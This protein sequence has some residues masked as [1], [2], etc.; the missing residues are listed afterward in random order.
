MASSPSQNEYE[1]PPRSLSDDTSDDNSPTQRTAGQ[2]M[3]YGTIS[4]V[5]DPQSTQA[6]Q[7]STSSAHHHRRASSFTSSHDRSRKPPIVRRMSSRPIRG[8]EFSVLDDPAELLQDHARKASSQNLRASSSLRKRSNVPQTPTLVEVD[9]GEDSQTEARAR[10][11]DEPAPFAEDED[12]EGSYDESDAHSIISNA[13]SFTLKDR[14]QAINQT[15]PFG[16]RIWKPA[17]YKK[18]R[19][20]E[21]TTEGDIHSAPGERVSPWL[22]LANILWTV[23]FGWW[24]ALIS[25]VGALVCHAVTFSP[26]AAAYARVFVGL[27]GYLFYPFG[28]YVLLESDE[29]YADEDVGEG[30]SISEWERWQSGDLE[31]GRLFFGPNDG[32]SARRSSLE[33][34][35]A[36]ER[37]RL[38]GPST[39]AA[40]AGTAPGAAGSNS[41]EEQ[42]NRKRRFFGRGKWSIARVVFYA[43]FYC[44]VGPP[45]FL[46]ALICWISVVGIPMGRV[47]LILYRHIRRHPLALSFH[48]DPKDSRATDRPSSILL[49]TYRAA[50]L[51]YWKY[52]I[53]GTNIFFINLMVVVLF[54]IF[55]YFVLY[56]GFGVQSGVAN[57]G[58]IFVLGLL[59]VI[60]LAYFIGQAVASISAQS[61]M[62][63]GAAVNAF[64]STVVEVYLYCVALTEGKSALV[65]G[66]IIGSILA[67]ILF[68]PGISMCFGA[69][70]RKTQRFN[71]KSAGV[72]STMLLFAMIAAFG[73]TIFYQVYGSHELNCFSCTEANA[74][75]RDCR[76]CYFSQEPAATDQ[77]YQ[78]AVLPYSYIAAI[79]LFFSYIIGLCP[80]VIRDS[81][82]FSRI[83]GQSLDSLGLARDDTARG[84]APASAGASAPAAS[85]GDAASQEMAG[86]VSSVTPDLASAGKPVAAVTAKGAA[87]QPALAG[88][89][90][91]SKEE[92]E[93][94]IRQITEVAATA[95]AIAARDAARLRKATALAAPTTRPGDAAK[96]AAQHPQ[97]AAGHV[98]EN[99]VGAITAQQL[100]S[101]TPETPSAGH[102]APNWSKTKSSVILLGTTVL[103]AIIAEILVK[104]VDVVLESVEIEEKFLGITLFALVPNTTEF[105][106][107]ISFAMNG[108]IALSM[109]IGSAYA[110]QVCLLQIPALVFFSG[111]YSTYLQDTELLSHTFNLIFPHWDTVT[112]ILCVFLLSY[113]YGEGKS[114]YFKGS[115]LVLTY[116]FVV[117]GFYFSD[118]NS[119]DQVQIT[120]PAA[121]AGG[122]TGRWKVGVVGAGDALSRA[123]VSGVAA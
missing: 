113:M 45:L 96:G 90:S 119:L 8:Q 114:N 49:C 2:S 53:D 94:L 35:G 10:T 78:R 99:E 117:M 95:A 34:T 6:D 24:L 112:I 21:R 102:D 52:T 17:V 84:A 69:L 86:R 40:H 56:E 80:S 36:S 109:E 30:R 51:K 88:L 9:S 91:L 81:V 55:D 79:F 110:L 98:V 48:Q 13:E 42:T 77:F 41:D 75:T 122:A 62:G 68:L 29:N 5:N 38:L 31:H 58:L 7:Q 83:L 39:A 115:I 74:S 89:P 3:S 121:S 23:L 16:I 97:A 43:Y 63:L 100:K 108:N 87:V 72:T 54:T 37:D 61:S 59:S 70:V 93:A 76:R 107:A 104:T 101:Q 82:L 11:S 15:H 105:L 25:V 73:P 1:E 28:S 120:E 116:I 27:A 50:G 20:I 33:S 19:S 32:G 57:L 103:Y 14:Q 111:I 85:P 118:F 67:G 18:L 106:N 60:P 47:T 66:S 12:T 92:N 123:A 44:F 46:V 71:D 64:F 4:S 65:E 26:S 22:L